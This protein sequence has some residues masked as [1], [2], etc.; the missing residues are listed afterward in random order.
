MAKSDVY[1]SQASAM[2]AGADESEGQR[3]GTL[4]NRPTGWRL[5]FDIVLL[6]PSAAPT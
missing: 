1:G 5:S 2:M 3:M 4:E 6:L